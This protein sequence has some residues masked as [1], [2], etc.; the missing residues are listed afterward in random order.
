M[1]KHTYILLVLGIT[2]L[3]GSCKKILELEPEQSIDAAT[4]IENDGDVEALTIGAYSI[5]GEGGLYGTNLFMITDLLA[6]EDYCSWAGTFSSYRQIA[7]RNM[8]PDNVD[9]T[10]TWRRAYAAI[11][12]ANIVLANLDKVS[13]AD[14]KQTLDGEAHFI[15]GIMLFELVRIYAQPWNPGGTNAG[16]GVVIRLTPTLT[17]TE[18]FTKTARSSIADVYTQVIKDLQDAATKMPEEN[19]T[20]ATKYTAL[21]FLSRVYLQKSDFPNA[22]S[23][24]NDVI[25]SEMY[26]MNASVGAVFSNKNTAESI[27]EIQQND[28]NNAGESNDGMATFYASFDGIGRADL[29][30]NTDFVD[31]YAAGDLRATEWYYIGTGRRSGN[32]YCRKWASFSQNLPVIRIA[33]MFLTRAECN[34]RLS[35]SVGDTPENDLAKVRNTVRTNLATITTP[36]LNDILN[37]RFHELAFE[38]TRIHD[39]KRL[40]INTGDY[41]W[42]ADELVFPIPQSDVDASEGVIV[43]NSGY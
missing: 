33:E 17:E 23:A 28:Q 21:A 26:K 22:L 5:M 18:A 36:T 31:T 24:A 19:G 29:R 20:R 11:N 25:E 38:G 7:R 34:V 13:D 43:Q 41:A 4:A 16:P 32:T 30:I 10:R 2:L 39:L 35:S 37:E 1:I 8:T 9:V 3:L 40:K 12:N 6:N 42:N 15:R 27:W 14:L